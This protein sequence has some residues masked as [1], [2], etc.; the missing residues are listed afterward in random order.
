LARKSSPRAA[1]SLSLTGGEGRGEGAGSG[2]L[3]NTRLTLPS[4]RDGPL[5]LP[6]EG[7]R[8]KK[9]TTTAQAAPVAAVHAKALD[10][11]AGL[12]GDNALRCIG[13]ACLDQ[14]LRNEAAVRA[15]VP[16]GIHQMRVAVRR[17]RAILA[18]FGRMLPADQRQPVSQ[19]LRWLGDA[20]GPARN[21]DVF[22][23]ALI[24]PAR[25]AG[26]QPDGIAALIAAAEC[27]RKAAYAK[28]IKAIRSTRY[29]RLILR[30]LRWFDSRAWHEGAAAQ[31]LRQ[32]IAALA[33]RILDRR[34]LVAERRAKGF[35]AQSA[36]ER[37][38]LRIG[39]K[40]LRYATEMLAGIYDADKVRRFTRR[41]KRLQDD[42]GDA[43]DVRVGHTIVAE[44][45]RSKGGASAIGDAGKIVLAWHE[46]RLAR[47]EPR[48]RRHLDGLLATE[49]FWSG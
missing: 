20:L 23:T 21:L 32:P 11:D 10:L 25:N 46:D 3:S 39:L 26:A 16:E 48:L 31:D 13:L 33:P 14:I 18:A 2:A 28:A 34:R 12:S 47:R 41:L 44:L 30:Q 36:A 35:A 17:L 5:P 29:A 7:R 6:P 19:E 38:R 22:Q 1:P 27:R 42:L 8:G 4:L 43:N 24:A 40:K 9:C 15:G 49:P 37:H 45:T